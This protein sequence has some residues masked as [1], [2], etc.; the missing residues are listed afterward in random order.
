MLYFKSLSHGCNQLITNGVCTV[1]TM[2]FNFHIVLTSV[3]TLLLQN[4]A[5]FHDKKTLD[6]EQL[7]VF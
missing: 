2:L 5:R 3:A 4:G 1:H 6:Y 7:I